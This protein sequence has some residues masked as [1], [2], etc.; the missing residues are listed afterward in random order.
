MSLWA[1]I[2]GVHPGPGRGDRFPRLELSWDEITRPDGFLD[3]LEKSRVQSAVTA[4]MPVDGQ[5]ILRLPSET[6]WEYAAR[7]G[8]FW[9]DDLRYS[10]SNDLDAVAWYKDNSGNQTHEV[11]RRAPNQ[12]GIYD[13][14]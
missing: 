12:L 7:G 3:R 1:H 8:P 9:R 4:Q 5:A 13:M 11:A 6:E 10:G 2:M 14:C